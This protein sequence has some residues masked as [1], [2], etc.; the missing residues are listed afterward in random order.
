M[1]TLNYMKYLLF[2][3]GFSIII[4]QE[5][6]KPEDTEVWDPEPVVVKPGVNNSAPSDAIVLFNGKDL[7]K[8]VN[9]RG[10]EEA[11]WIVNDDNSMT[12]TRNG[13]IETVEEFGSVQLHIEWKTP[14]EMDGKGQGRGNS[15]ILF[16][17][18]YEVQILDSYQNQTYSNGQAA[19]IYKQHAPLVNSS[20][21]PG[22]WQSYDIIFIEPEF[23]EIGITVKRGKFTVFHNGILVQNNVDILGTTEYI[24]MPNVG[25]KIVSKYMPGGLKKK[26]YLQDHGNPVAFRNIWLRRL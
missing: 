5:N 25:E 20:R 15:G 17:R 12:V 8:W 9:S 1:L 4:A 13:G 11:S 24:G 7:S 16:Q 6:P 18:R 22:E 21:P 19:S 23:N 2:F 14:K 10:G 26:L 3:I